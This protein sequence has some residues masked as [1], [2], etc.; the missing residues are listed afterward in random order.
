ME[1]AVESHIGGWFCNAAARAR[2]RP[3]AQP[4][5]RVRAPGHGRRRLDVHRRRGR[6]AEARAPRLEHARG[7]AR[8]GDVPDDLVERELDALR[9]AVAELAPVEGRPAQPGDTVVVDLVDL[10]GETQSDYVVELGRAGSSRRS[11]AGSSACRPARPRR[12]SCELADDQTASV[13]VT[14]KEIKEKVLPALDD[15]LA[16]TAS[17]FDTLAE[18]RADIEAPARASSSRTRPSRRSAA[19]SPTRSSTPRASRRPARSSRRARASSS[20]ASSAP[21]KR[22]AS[23]S[24][25]YL[26]PHRHQRRASSSRACARRRALR[27]AR[28]R[29]R[30][31]GR[32]AGHRRPRRGGR[33]ARAR[34]GRARR[35]RTP[36]RSLA[37][38]PR[39]TALYEQLREDL[40]LRDALDR[41]AAEVTPI[42]TE[43]A[44]ARE[45]LWT[46]D[47]EKPDT[48][49]KLWT[50]ASKEPA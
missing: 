17:E 26:A 10:S 8:G 15:E 40:R 33:G 46:P 24:R 23:R 37:E 38:T 34:A 4:E 1:E 50:P 32:R 29:A 22:A 35:A 11:S 25:R 14:L 6:A 21:S 9:G 28:A 16:R 30:G 7:A 42:S 12:S 36:T 39:T 19:R 18:L 3:V 31:R 5:L 27:R 44:A 41:V 13:E 45:Q 47:K 43:L 48:E 49:T 20:T 2:I